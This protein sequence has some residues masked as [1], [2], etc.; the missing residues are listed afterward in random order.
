MSDTL[1]VYR[2]QGGPERPKDGSTGLWIAI[3]VLCA[4]GAAAGWYFF[5][6]KEPVAAAVPDAGAPAKPT[7]PPNLV[8]D[9][10]VRQLAQPL[11][12]ESAWAQ[13]LAENDLVRTFTTVVYNV[14]EGES[15]RT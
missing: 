8:T 3:L 2:D 7:L 11:S 1:N 14:S 15:P 10:R 9:A 6:P 12:T 13:W 4:I 5:R